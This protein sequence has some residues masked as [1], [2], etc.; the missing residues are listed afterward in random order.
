MCRA[1]RYKSSV[2]CSSPALTKFVR[3]FLFTFR[4]FKFP[5]KDHG[6]KR[7]RFFAFGLY[8]YRS[9]DWSGLDPP[10]LVYALQ[11]DQAEVRKR[12]GATYSL[13]GSHDWRRQLIKKTDVAK[14]LLR[15]TGLLQLRFFSGLTRTMLNPKT[16]GVRS[17]GRRSF[18]ARR[19]FP[20]C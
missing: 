9:N 4:S 6:I 15:T 17:E 13:H 20:S 19:I 18:M 8:V 1:S 16:A 11:A 14:G 10:L 3:Q 12:S 2:S 5:G 7:P